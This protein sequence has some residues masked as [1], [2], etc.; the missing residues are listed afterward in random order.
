MGDLVG[1]MFEITAQ[2]RG[3]LWRLSEDEKKAWGDAMANCLR[4]V[5]MPEKQVGIAA[6]IVALGFVAYATVVPRLNADRAA[7]NAAQGT[8]RTEVA[9]V[10]PFP[11]T[12]TGE[13]IARPLIG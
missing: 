9:P 10:V 2:R 13:D 1:V 3:E 4:H 7:L 5:P 8:Q 12:E 6:D 11:Q